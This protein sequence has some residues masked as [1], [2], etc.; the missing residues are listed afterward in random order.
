MNLTTAIENYMPREK[1]IMQIQ[2]YFSAYADKTRIKI[3]S[4]L[5][6][7]EMSVN[8]ICQCLNLK[9][10][11]VSHQLKMLKDFGL[12]DYKRLGKQ[13]VYFINNNLVEKTMFIGSMA[14]S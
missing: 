13:K 12:I 1:D 5:S 8:N 6:I 11:T 4:L 3:L 9:Q 2:E 7:S 10:S 14:I